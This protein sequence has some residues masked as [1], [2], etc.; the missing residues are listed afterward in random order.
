MPFQP[1]A[2]I[3]VLNYSGRHHLERCLPSLAR[4]SY[5][6]ASVVVVDNG[7]T[8]DSLDY[9]RRQH[10]DVKVLALGSNRGFAPAYNIAV[11]ESD[12]EVVVLLNNDT[13]V[14]PEWLG[15]LVDVLERHQSS[16]AASCMLDWDGCHIDFAGVLPTFAGH[17]WQ[18]DSGRPVGATYTEQP[19][20]FGCAGSLAIRREAFVEVGGFDDD[21][22]TY[23]EDLD[24]GWR[25]SLA[26]HTTILAPEAITYHRLHATAG[27][28]GQ[29]LRLRLY[30]RNAL[31][32][33]FKN[34]DDESL[35][36]ILPAAIALTVGRAFAQAKLDDHAVRF[37]HPTPDRMHLPPRV[38]AT[39][40]ALEDV[41]RHLPRLQEKR[42]QVQAMRRRSD[43]DIFALFP[44]P[45]R[46]HEAGDRYRE[47]AEALI[48]D[49]RIDALFGIQGA[50][51]VAVGRAP[52]AASGV[53]ETHPPRIEAGASD[54]PLVSVIVL[55]A[56]GARHLPDCLDSLRQH[57][58]PA[59]RTEVIVVDNGSDEDPSEIAQWHYPGVRVI[60]SS[61]NLG[62]SGGNNL[63]AR[64]A[65]GGWLAFLNDDTRV[66]PGWLTEMM[67]V[68]ERRRAASVGAFIVDW[69][70]QRV[71]FAGGLMNFEGRGYSLGHGLDV[72]DGD[73]SERPL[74]FGCGAAVM[75]RRDVFDAA[76]AWDEPTFAYY[77]D[78]EFGWRLWALGHEV[79]FAPNAVV[80]HKH[81]GTSGG[82]SPARAR[83]FER[84]ALRMLYALLEEDTLRRVLPA[85]L[86]LATDRLLLE[87]PFSRAHEDV[88]REREPG[89]GRDRVPL[90]AIKIRLL[91][92]L[93]QRGARRQYSAWTN[94]RRVGAVGIAGAFMDTAR[95]TA[96]TWR[97]SDARAAYIIE[98]T[99][100]SAAVDMRHDLLPSVTIGKLLGLGDF[101][102][103][104]PELTAR[105]AWLQERRQRSDAEI[106]AR[107]GD[108]W[109]AAVPSA[110]GDLHATLRDPLMAVLRLGHDLTAAASAPPLS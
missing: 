58:W 16:A 7:S 37:G 104:L 72:A 40:L 73:R 107:F 35:A 86:L 12:A 23:F 6:N 81:H 65:S 92:A 68:A 97:G 57:E 11:R 45:L 28:W 30:E 94:L 103:M 47:A 59:D 66:D 90:R 44:E 106:L 88:A 13:R 9:V 89:P 41:A 25:M 70:G 64:A 96:K 24:L 55:T 50:Q 2:A 18:V 51:R 79:W 52:V 10:P 101:L 49:F 102:A 27:E 91:Q 34:Y 84:N 42:R 74:L 76:G 77:E 62:F 43:A 29:A 78:V 36:R 80:Y 17:S 21:Y 19:L 26:G 53:G 8:D 85:A 54:R 95:D 75:F 71:D 33:I 48:R 3:L 63:G 99:G 87:T 61:R 108:R 46:L 32:T 14:E 105:R 69:Q 109:T 39:L 20:L 1:R 5:P 100:P 82:E 38:I 15:Q 93:S 31:Y 56:S 98:R 4:L 67:A 83:A 60:R 22:F 110:R